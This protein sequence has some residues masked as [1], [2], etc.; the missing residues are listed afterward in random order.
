MFGNEIRE[1]F[2]ILKQRVNDKPLIYL[3]SAATAHKPLAVI[4]AVDDF[5]RNYNSNIHRGSHALALRATDAYE[6]AREKV[7]KFINARHDSEIVFNR[8]ASSGINFVAQSYGM[9]NVN[10]GDEILISL[11]E[12][13]SNIIPWQQLAKKRGAVLKY[14]PLYPDGTIKLAD[15][16]EMVTDRTKIVAITHISNVLGTINPVKEIV[17]IAH[18]KGAV[19]LI[20]GAQGAPHKRV[21]VQNINCDFYIIS[22]HKMGGPTGIG[23]VYG[24][25]QLLDNME[26]IEFGGEMMG[27]VGLYDST[28]KDAPLKFETGTMPIAGAIG[29]GAMIDFLEE[30]GMDKVEAHENELVNY[31]LGRFA[32]FPGL[33]IYGPL[34]NRSSLISFNLEGVHPHDIAT[35]LDLAGIAIRAGEHCAEPLT[36]F[37]QVPATARASFY[38]YNTREEI[39]ILYSELEKTKEYFGNVFA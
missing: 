28:W 14:L 15:V 21:D 26:P 20:D 30:I 17:E 23:A 6:A 24:K 33:T 11:M 12:H 2:P 37:L 38:I 1:Q 7:R 34:T 39:D 5:Y 10:E 4:N 36:R 16:R 18:Q 22:G 32:N 13:H 8:G 27:T 25:K 29:L 35:V 3:D 19:V 31:A 9:A